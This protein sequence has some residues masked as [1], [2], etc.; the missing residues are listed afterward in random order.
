MVQLVV[1]LSTVMFVIYL[2]DCL[3]CC[4]VWQHPC[5][6][7]FDQQELVGVK[8]HHS[9]PFLPRREPLLLIS[10]SSLELIYRQLTDLKPAA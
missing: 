8:Q 5:R 2:G 1:G 9:T 3:L 4:G 7:D 10:D 6:V